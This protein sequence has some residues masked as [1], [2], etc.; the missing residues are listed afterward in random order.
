MKK[1]ITAVIHCDGVLLL[2]DWMRSKGAKL[3]VEI[4]DTMGIKTF[5]S[6]KNLEHFYQN[7]PR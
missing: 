7:E 5:N 3:E 2:D 6:I 1:C 4:C